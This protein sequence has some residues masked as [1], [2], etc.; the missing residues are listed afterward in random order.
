MAGAQEQ[1]SEFLD[2]EDF[3]AI[4]IEEMFIY[5]QYFGQFQP[6]NQMHYTV[7]LKRTADQKT[8]HNTQKKNVTKSIFRVHAMFIFESNEQNQRKKH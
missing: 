5:R 3:I 2:F 6:S 4:I 1:Y 8:Y 7:S